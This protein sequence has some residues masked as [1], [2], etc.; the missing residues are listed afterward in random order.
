MMPELSQ[1][2][3]Y[4]GRPGSPPGYRMIHLRS[5]PPPGALPYVLTPDIARAITFIA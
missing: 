5:P 4:L 2:N 3:R 1:P